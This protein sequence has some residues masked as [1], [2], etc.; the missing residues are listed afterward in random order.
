VGLPSNLLNMPI[1]NNKRVNFQSCGSKQELALFRGHA[2][3]FGRGQYRHVHFVTRG[4]NMVRSRFPPTGNIYLSSFQV[5]ESAVTKSH[6]YGRR[7][8]SQL[9]R[10]NGPSYRIGGFVYTYHGTFLFFPC[11]AGAGIDVTAN[12]LLPSFSIAWA[13]LH[14]PSC[15]IWKFHSL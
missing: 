9:Y 5:H 2:C 14:Y 6:A 3:S 4:E 11:E 13:A 1:H 12:R 10:S 7:R 8:R 15:L